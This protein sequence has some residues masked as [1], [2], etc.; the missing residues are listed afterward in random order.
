MSIPTHVQSYRSVDIKSQA[1]SSS[2]I[3]SVHIDPALRPLS[4]AFI[5]AV[6]KSTYFPIH[7]GTSRLQRP[8]YQLHRPAAS[9]WPLQWKHQDCTF[10]SSPVK[11]L[12]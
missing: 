11:T 5:A 2:C 12:R 7:R 8:F 4:G 1:H 10:H 9:S 6:L 3:Y